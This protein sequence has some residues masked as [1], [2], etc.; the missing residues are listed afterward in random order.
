MHCS[1][2]L[3]IS[4]SSYMFRRI[5]S[6]SGSLLLC[7]LL[8]YIEDA[9]GFMIHVCARTASKSVD[10]FTAFIAKYPFLPTTSARSLVQLRS[11][12]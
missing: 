6:S 2:S 3:L 5:T 9:Y 1:D 11:T 7:V 4:Y 8:G 10:G 12:N